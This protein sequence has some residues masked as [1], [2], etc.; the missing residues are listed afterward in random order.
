M[1]TWSA[2]A[3]AVLGGVLTAAGVLDVTP[4][5]VFVVVGGLS[6]LAGLVN[7]GTRGSVALLAAGLWPVAFSA[8]GLAEQWVL[9][10]GGLLVVAAAFVVVAAG[11][12]EPAPGTAG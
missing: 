2:V 6:A 10:S 9:L 5:W 7:L 11:T 3:A 1:R 8:A 12:T 4:A